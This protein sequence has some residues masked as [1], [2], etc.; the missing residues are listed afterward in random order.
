MLLDKHI[1]AIGEINIKNITL[2]YLIAK[3]INIDIEPKEIKLSIKELKVKKHLED[4]YK[5][6]G[7]LSYN[8]LKIRK[9][10]TKDIKGRE[11]ED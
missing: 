1:I 7:K 5:L 2:V 10:K 8:E 3:L 9:N 6:V 11:R 4:T